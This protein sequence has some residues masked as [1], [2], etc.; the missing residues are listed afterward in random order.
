MK[1]AAFPCLPVLMVSFACV[2]PL[3]AQTPAKAPTID[4]SLEMMQ[5][6][7]PKIS[8]DGK[9]VVYEQRRTNWENN[10]FDRELW[11]ADTGSGE[12]HPL[13]ARVGS[14]DNAEWSPDGRSIAFL[15]DRPGQLKDSPAGKT[16]LYIL[17][18][19]GG[20]AQQI[21]K[22]ENGVNDFA[23]SPDGKHIAL[24]AE[25][26]EPKA[27]KDRKETF[28]DYHVIHADYQMVHL[29]LVDV[30]QADASGRLPKLE[31]PK[32]L[33]KGDEFSVDGFSFSPDGAR[34]AFSAQRDPDLISGFSADIYTV[35]VADGAVK[36]IVETAGPDQNPKWSPD[37][38]QIAFETASGAK[39]FYYTNSRIAVV[40]S[41]GGT[42]QVL[43]EG[44][45]E[46]PG[47]L[48]WAPGGI[49]F[50]A[51]QKTAAS[52]FVLDP[53]TKAVKTGC[54]AGYDHCQR[55]FVFEGLLAGGLHGVGG[56][57]IL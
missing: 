2:G 4:Q 8:P 47:L 27:M 20:E 36:K 18:A 37:G 17:P 19:D 23:W 10:S 43:T 50:E 9:R 46:S 1:R 40:P 54:V 51:T 42:P 12:R 25:G 7:S 39:Y 35:T 41:D 34:I 14:S 29:W 13:T 32:Q 31:D 52:L 15:S 22:L 33:T 11:I 38:K 28:G 3:R 55:I 53:A 26:A 21:T 48:R 30:P 24:A 49:Y 56:Q 16:Q 57:S 44:F 6:G 5:V 45:D